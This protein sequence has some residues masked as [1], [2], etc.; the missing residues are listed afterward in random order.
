MKK[1][2]Y[3]I[4]IMFAVFIGIGTMSTT[5]VFASESSEN[6]YII[7]AETNPDGL[8]YDTLST[9]NLIC[10][11]SGQTLEIKDVKIILNNC[12]ISN[13]IVI[14]NG[15]EL[16]LSNV[17][18]VI[19]NTNVNNV[20]ENNG[21]VTL[22]NVT[23]PSVNL[24]IVSIYNNS[25]L[26]GAITINKMSV[27]NNYIP[28]IKLMAGS[29]FVTE[30]TEIIG[31]INIELDKNYNALDESI[32]GRPLVRGINAFA[33]RFLNNFRLKDAPNEESDLVLDS[34]DCMFKKFINNYYI[35]YAGMLGDDLS[36]ESDVFTITNSGAT[37]SIKSGDIIVTKYCIRLNKDDDDT[38]NSIV[39]SDGFVYVGGKYA[40]ARMFINNAHVTFYVK[41]IIV[42]NK[43]DSSTGR[44]FC[45]DNVTALVGNSKG[46]L[47]RPN[48]DIKCVALDE[49]FT[50]ILSI[51]IPNEDNSIT[52][53]YNYLPTPIDAIVN[54]TNETY[55]SKVM[56]ILGK[57]NFEYVL[58]NY[59]DLCNYTIVNEFENC[60]TWILVVQ[61]NKDFDKASLSLSLRQAVQTKNITLE[62]T[63]TSVE[64]DGQNHIND[65]L[66][67]YTTSDETGVL[68]AYDV[69]FYKI[70]GNSEN[71]C[72][73]VRDAGN[74]KVVV[75]E[76]ENV[77]FS[78]TEFTFKITS[79]VL[80]L[81]IQNSYSY[82]GNKKQTIVT[83]KNLVEGDDLQISITNNDGYIN[84]GKYEQ[85]IEIGNPNYVIIVEQKYVTLIIDK[86]IISDDEM[87]KIIYESVTGTYAP[88][89]TYKVEPQNVP[90]GVSY[91]FTN[92]KNEFNNAGEYLVTIRFDIID[93]ANFVFESSSYRNKMATVTINKR[94]INTN[95]IVFTDINTD[96]NGKN[97]EPSVNSDLP[98]QVSKVVYTYTLN[99]EIVDQIINASDTPYIVTAKL[100]LADKYKNNYTLSK[101][102]FAIN[103]KINRID[104]DLN[105][106]TFNGE[107]YD[108]LVKTYVFDGLER[109]IRLDDT[110]S[111]ILLVE[112][113]RVSARSVGEYNYYALVSVC[114]SN[115]NDFGSKT[116]SAKMIITPKT[117]DTTSIVFS[118]KSVVYSNENHTLE[119]ENV[120]S[121]L[122]VGYEYY[123]D[124]VLVS[125]DG[126]TNVGEYKVI[127]KFGFVR[128]PE[129][130]NPV[131]NMSA[132]LTINCKEIN[133][134]DVTFSNQTIV[135]NGKEHKAL[136]NNIH[137][138]ITFEYTTY[139][140]QDDGSTILFDNP[141]INVG[142]YIIY[143]TPKYDG[144]N[145]CLINYSLSPATLTITPATYDMSK[146]KFVSK[147]YTY[148]GKSKSVRINESALP[149][150]VR[151]LEYISS[152]AINAGTYTAQVKFAHDNP[153]YK[154]P[155]NLTCN[156]I[157]LPKQIEIYLQ[158]S[159][160]VYTG[161]K[162]NLVPLASGVLAGDQV[163]IVLGEYN[164]INVGTY[165]VK[166]SSLGNSNYISNQ[167]VSYNIKKADVDLSKVNFK[168]ITC[169]YDGLEHIP[170][171]SGDLPSGIIVNII[172]SKAVS[173]GTYITY[174]EFKCVNS[175]Y[176]TPNRLSAKT[177]IT[178][179]KILTEFI[180]DDVFVEDGK[181]KS[182]DV[183]FVGTCET[184]FNDYEIVYSNTP[185]KAGIYTAKIVLTTNNYIL[186]SD[187]TFEFEIL[188][189]VKTYSDDKLALTIT[190]SGFSNNSKLSLKDTEN[191]VSQLDNKIG[192]S[193]TISAF[194]LQLSDS[195]YRQEVILNLKINN[196][197]NYN[198][199]NIKV[200]KIVDN[201]LREL[202]YTLVASTLQ[203]LAN[204]DDEIVILE[205]PNSNNVA[206]TYLIIASTLV[207]I[208]CATIVILKT[209]KKKQKNPNYFVDIDD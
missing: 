202:D 99:G 80:D 30:N 20:I 72:D 176:N 143:A 28:T 7:D 22:D 148:D 172:K 122:T 110:F 151:V 24:K 69:E 160:F 36:N 29:I 125:R 168:D 154:D 174:A 139:K 182:V 193:K 15:G 73:N 165:R 14:E 49:T 136:V 109:E 50:Q 77:V 196:I 84:A 131:S 115:Y 130:Y 62:M 81:D 53:K 179:R 39:A 121:E 58:N 186:L 98:E 209:R 51:D 180:K 184:N 152:D 68:G 127:A 65:F 93:T 87:S 19:T 64:Y 17:D 3:L 85:T 23:F 2:L 88:N 104:F 177:T 134:S 75:K 82:D 27:E 44:Y 95:N 6:T 113:K 31:T 42:E 9:D 197:S 162:C 185:I 117:I 67:T 120:P 63:N 163:N 178:P 102:T 97:I 169:E 204:I 103:V 195:E 164:D 90:S 200:Y 11:K 78:Q 147:T 129:N 206:L 34:D 13:V 16:K 60:N 89:K 190:S 128:E 153:N 54:D 188:T 105:K 40:T 191:S 71:I 140:V 12:E 149:D 41:G 170:V 38:N 203:F 8:R 108:G 207:L 119:C 181:Q 124:D 61:A 47:T 194:K 201:E 183:R 55:S 141:I 118:D 33:G 10:V 37:Y 101:D 74:Y 48:Q 159:E 5:S 133:M 35:D 175:N 171:F 208:I 57:S 192:K 138:D 123:L 76:K 21:I 167:Y 132:T 173:V 205:M 137:S 45:L 96:Y 100:I 94:E 70:N 145:I 187:D 43:I 32:I 114:N 59:N 142:T 166:V 112:E 156:L 135:Y 83:P 150:G 111:D 155:Q 25:D 198:S 199:K 1:I 52:T 56:I 107:I 18:F 66:P 158:K 126:V 157:I 26:Y 46:N 189:K 86:K 161:E 91:S 92:G 79:R 116:L 144:N 146:V 4:I 106:L